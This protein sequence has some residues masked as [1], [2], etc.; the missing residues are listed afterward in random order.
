MSWIKSVFKVVIREIN[1]IIKDSDLI[2][3]LIAAP[4][5]Y[6]FYYGSM[7][8]NKSESKVPIAILDMDHSQSSKDFVKDLNAS[9]YIKVKE[10]LHSSSQIEDKLI[11]EEVQGVVFIPSDFESDITQMRSTEIK[12]YL[13]TQRFLHSNDLNKAVNQIALAK[14]EEIRTK[15]FISKGFS[16]AQAKEMSTPLKDEVTF[17]FNPSEAY[18][19]FLIPAI[20]ILILQQTLFM[21]LGQSMAKENEINKINELISTAGNSFSAAIFG[22]ILFYVILY[23]SYA[24]LFFTL[25]YYIFN[26]NFAGNYFTFTLLTVFMF[27]SMSAISVFIGSFFTKKIYALVLISFTSY[28]LFF[29]AGYSWPTFAMPKL[30]QLFSYIIPTTPYMQSIN[31]VAMMGAG[32]NQILFELLNLIVLSVIFLFLAFFRLKLIAKK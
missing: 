19:D 1:W 3:M 18:G 22:K 2:L 24:F 17:L 21:G 11:S 8:I 15:I 5:F 16:N 30:V 27:I 9:A 23:L 31:R 13:N 12:L 4:I 14:G 25:N 10:Y 6:S 7:Y 32:L 20:L 28:P 26:L 29:F